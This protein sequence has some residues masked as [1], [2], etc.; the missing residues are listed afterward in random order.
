MLI[1]LTV[2]E[3]AQ[4]LADG[5]PTPGGGSA[6]ALAGALGAGLV[7]MFCEI[8]DGRKKYAEVKAEME[9]TA[10]FARQWQARLLE[11]VDL[12]SAAYDKVLAAYRLPKETDPEKAARRQ[13]IDAANLEA[14]RTPLETAS[15][16]VQV[17]G[18]IAPLAA[19][20]NPN[21][22][23]DLKVGLELLATAFA[24]A[25]ANVEINLPWL[26]EEAGAV[27]RRQIETLGAKAHRA[28]EEG[29]QAIA[30]VQA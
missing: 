21:A 12:D 5:N 27:I 14:T 19:K 17:L 7:S 2:Q 22:I 9:E 28:A 26:P 25:R 6:A 30:R 8:P 13:A 29:R 20:G 11:L 15:C 18:R 1:K 16:C 24:G 3:F 10:R 23:S 4:R